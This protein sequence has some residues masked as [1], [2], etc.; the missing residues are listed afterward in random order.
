LLS[1]TLI[2]I[3]IVFAGL[4][5][6]VWLTGLMLRMQIKLVAVALGRQDFSLSDAFNK[7]VGN[8][9]RLAGLLWLLMIV[10]LVVG[11]VSLAARYAFSMTGL[12]Y[13]WVGSEIVN[14]TVQWFTTLLAITLLTMLYE[15]FV[16]DKTF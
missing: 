10:L 7:T 4:P 12:S 9:W 15:F 13:A 2:S 14:E 5:F 1:K 3:I 8:T 16:E 6:F 11:L